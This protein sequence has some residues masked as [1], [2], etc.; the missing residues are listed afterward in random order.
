MR[1]GMQIGDKLRGNFAILP[2]WAWGARLQ[3]GA[4]AVAPDR[5]PAAPTCCAA[6]PT[7]A[8]RTGPPDGGAGPGGAEPAPRR[9]RAVEVLAALGG[10]DLAVMVGVMLVAPAAATC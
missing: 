8:E 7:W 5:L 6:A 3:R 2:A 10:F 9:H 4:G 1:A